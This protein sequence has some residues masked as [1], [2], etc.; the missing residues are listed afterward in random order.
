MSWTE[1]CK[2]TKEVAWDI[3]EVLAGTGLILVIV[4]L[5]KGGF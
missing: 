3:A 4:D 5:V 2:Q 1:I